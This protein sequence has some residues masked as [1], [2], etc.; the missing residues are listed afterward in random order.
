MLKLHQYN[1]TLQLIH[2]FSISGNTRNSTALVFVELS[3]ENFVG[4][5]EASLP[6]YL[7]ESQES[8]YAFLQKVNLNEFK[9]PFDADEIVVYLDSIEKGNTAAKAAVD[10]ALHDLIGK[11]AGKPCHEI[12]EIDKSK[13]P[14]TSITIG[15]DRKEVIQQKVKEAGD[16]KLL[17]VKLG[18][19]NDKEIIET[20]REITDKAICVDVNQGWHD[21]HFALEMAHWLSEKN[22]IFIEQAMPK[23]QLNDAA[24]FTANSPLPHIADEAVQRLS[25]IDKIKDAYDG[26]NIKLMKCTGLNEAMRMVK[27]ARAHNLKVLIGCMN[28]SS[29]ANMAAAQ[30]APMAD[31][32]DLDGP[33]MISNNPFETPQLLDGK[34]VLPSVPGIGVV[35]K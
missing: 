18:Q 25:D 6:P 21:K 26:I 27:H 24:W 7:G 23:H 13:M 12:F 34:I 32:V 29:C 8:V 9:F 28:E 4:Y 31:W 17:K 1:Y 19:G 10:I 11:I 33:F 30:L 15:I 2:P 22:V 14:V 16:F 35:K 5:G 20:I 3:Y